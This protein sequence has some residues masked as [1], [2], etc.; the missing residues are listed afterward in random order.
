MYLSDAIRIR[1]K[2][3]IKENNTNGNQ[4]ALIAGF[5]RS[6]INK[7]LRKQNK[8]IKIETISLICQALNIGLKDFFDDKVFDDVEVND[9][10]F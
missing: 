3:L 7:F 10:K 4:L 2:N 1:L 5:N 8:S 9:W 6:N